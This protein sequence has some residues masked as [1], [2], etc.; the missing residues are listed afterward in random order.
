MAQKHPDDHADFFYVTKNEKQFSLLQIPSTSDSLV[1][2]RIEE[3]N[4]DLSLE[5]FAENLSSLAL[6][7]RLVS[8]AVKGHVD[9]EIKVCKILKSVTK[10]CDET[11]HTLNDFK[12]SCHASLKN[13]STA[14]GYLKDELEDQA[15]SLLKYLKETPKKM[16][17]RSSDLTK[18]CEE[19]VREI[20]EVES[21]IMIEKAELIGS[22]EEQEKI[23]K[24]SE[25]ESEINKIQSK[26]A[27]EEATSVQQ[28]SREAKKKQEEAREHSLKVLN[29]KESMLK[30]I[31]Q[32]LDEKKAQIQKDYSAKEKK[33]TA[34]LVKT[35]KA[36]QNEYKKAIEESQLIFEKTMKSTQV[37]HVATVQ[38][39]K[40][41]FD[42]KMQSNQDTYNTTKQKIMDTYEKCIQQNRETYAC[43]IQSNETEYE[44]AKESCE[45]MYRDSINQ[46]AENSK[47]E[48]IQNQQ[49]LDDRLKQNEDELKLK[50]I[51]H[52]LE[53]EK[54]LQDM[55]NDP[56]LHIPEAVSLSDLEAAIIK[57][58]EQQLKENEEKYRNLK[59]Q[60][61][62]D[63]TE[64]LQSRT[65]ELNSQ[66]SKIDSE[67][68]DDDK[69]VERAVNEIQMPEGPEFLESINPIS[70][71]E[72]RQKYDA[73][74]DA[75]KAQKRALQDEYEAKNRKR[76]AGRASAR[77][78]CD[79]AIRDLQSERS[80][81]TDDLEQQRQKWNNEA[82]TS[83]DSAI[84]KAQ[85][86]K[87]TIDEKIASVKQLRYNFKAKADT[88]KLEN[89]RNAQKTKLS[90]DALG[91]QHKN[92]ADKMVKTEKA[93]LDKEAYTIKMQCIDKANKVKQEANT[94]AESKKAKADELAYSQKEKDIQDALNVLQLSKKQ[95]EKEKENADV[96]ANQIKCEA[97]EASEKTKKNRDD[98]A[99]DTKKIKTDEYNLNMNKQLEAA[100]SLLQDQL[101]DL[102]KTAD[103]EKQEVEQST[104][105]ILNIQKQEWEKWQKNERELETKAEEM[106]KKKEIHDIKMAEAALRIQKAVKQKKI[107]GSAKDCLDETVT[108]LRSIEDTMSAAYNFWNEMKF[109]CEDADESL[110][111]HLECILLNDAYGAD[112]RRL[113]WS[114][115]TFKQQV[116][117]FYA[118]WAALEEVCSEASKAIKY[119]KVDVHRYVREN[120]SDSEA[121]VLVEK[122]TKEFQQKVPDITDKETELNDE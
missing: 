99:E 112:K 76:T 51:N 32:N 13:L 21:D 8:C 47:A 100:A 1:I 6:F 97:N 102:N 59:N 88:K 94:K 104:E 118:E 119:V 35:M 44:D 111:Q 106:K 121:K 42:K 7:I 57:D 20:E 50:I 79:T 40:Q 87:E 115:E 85:H 36:A 68:R 28:K 65:S 55:E 69:Y 71:D 108:A 54:K 15:I 37:T 96:A 95:A 29:E 11:V 78:I 84:I 92:D 103:K 81:K 90:N 56:N 60:T 70:K 17:K 62:R 61:E 113:I 9:L 22:I 80:R 2:S 26:S 23:I 48:L 12:I 82:R 64:K 74:M 34:L 53:Y 46:N 122:L 16:I 24:V 4:D 39:N 110:I 117:R 5:T 3:I 10:L 41:E 98:Q 93:R 67:Q 72:R 101:K 120:L 14:Y 52:D 30:K 83:K 49:N 19:Q 66:L 86:D 45:E 109:F 116:L 107:Q 63:Y 31:N 38:Q 18:L 73:K 77:N 89:N 75:A 27:D 25:N 43:E 33:L 91:K 105:E 114:S 58:Y